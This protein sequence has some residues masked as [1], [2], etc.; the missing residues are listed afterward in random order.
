MP[1]EDE[2]MDDF[3]QGGDGQ[4][5]GPLKEPHDGVS[6]AP[7][8]STPPAPRQPQGPRPGSLRERRKRDPRFR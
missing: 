3:T 5:F 4:V 2:S 6:S 8:P 7:V 1:I